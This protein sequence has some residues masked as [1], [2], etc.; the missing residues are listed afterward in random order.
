MAAQ[1]LQRTGSCGQRG[2]ALMEQQQE[3]QGA[4]CSAS[5][6]SP[7]NGCASSSGSGS[8]SYSPTKHCTAALHA[9]GSSSLHACNSSDQHKSIII[10]SSSSM[11]GV[12][13]PPSS[14]GGSDAHHPSRRDAPRQ[15]HGGGG[16]LARTTAAVALALVVAL[17]VLGPRPAHAYGTEIGSSVALFRF[18]DLNVAEYIAGQN[19][20]RCV[21]MVN[22]AGRTG[23]NRINFVISHYFVDKDKDFIVDY[24]CLKLSGESGCFLEGGSADLPVWCASLACACG[25][26]LVWC[27]AAEG[28]CCP[29]PSPSPPAPPP[30][31][32]PPPRRQ[33]PPSAPPPPSS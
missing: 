25:V 4:C 33:A 11:Q 20:T 30:P 12:A 16:S 13:C 8:E 15:R 5:M 7:T 17:C 32:R 26:V 22:R 19:A 10:I 6:D 31:P 18:V 3:Q 9:F 24:Y 2:S 21:H 14:S 23:S 29:A 1:L 28:G 27:A